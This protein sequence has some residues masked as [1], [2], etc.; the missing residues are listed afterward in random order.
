MVDVQDILDRL[1]LRHKDQIL[2]GAVV[3]ED[4]SKILGHANPTVTQNIYVT[5]FDPELKDAAESFTIAPG[6][7]S[8]K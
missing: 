6:Q 7:R 2:N 5:V 8:L 4:L 3:L 1:G